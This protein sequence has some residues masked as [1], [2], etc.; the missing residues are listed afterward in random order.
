[1]ILPARVFFSDNLEWP[2]KT[3]AELYRA[4]WAVELFFKEPKQMCP[5]RTPF[6][7]RG[8]YRSRCLQWVGFVLFPINRPLRSVPHRVQHREQLLDLRH[9][10]LL[11]G[12][13]R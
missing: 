3:V 8:F 10:R 4:R 11:L 7:F 6:V 12:Q 13:G 9:N 5:S 2:A 1:V